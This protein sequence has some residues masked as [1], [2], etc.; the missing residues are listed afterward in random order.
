MQKRTK[1][2]VKTNQKMQKQTK[3]NAKTNQKHCKNEPK[4]MQKRT[5]T[6]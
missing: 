6:M 1:N 3:H 5:K 2:N 4:T